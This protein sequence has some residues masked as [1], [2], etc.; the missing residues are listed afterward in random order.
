M[1]TFKIRVILV[2][3]M[4]NSAYLNLHAQN[5]F[6]E[7]QSNTNEGLDVEYFSQQEPEFQTNSASFDDDVDD[8]G[9]PLDNWLYILTFAG[10]G[11]GFYF[12]RKK[13]SMN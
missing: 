2:C 5:F 7:S 3:I 10:I 11:I 4:I 12:L 8:Q 6:S 13:P 1:I 9:V